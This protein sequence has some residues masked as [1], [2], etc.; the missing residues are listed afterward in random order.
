M[1]KLPIPDLMLKSIYEL[2]P[3]TLA[4]LGKTLL[5]MD[6]DNTLAKYHAAGPSVG[7]RNWVDSMKKADIEPFIYSNC[8]G[9]G[10]AR[11]ANALSVGFIHRARKPR[12]GRLLALLHAK[13]V[14]P[15]NAAII[16]DQIYTDVLCGARAGIMTIAVRPIS[17]KNPF[18]LLRYA[19]ELPFRYAYSGRLKKREKKA[20]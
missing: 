4:G 16:G 1:R 7:L 15:E 17:M 2:R 10:A 20:D 13:D 18:H 8:R 12:A 5:L 6:L 3:E 11:F 9:S 14:A 19:A